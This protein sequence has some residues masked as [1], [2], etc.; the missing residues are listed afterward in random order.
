[1]FARHAVNASRAATVV[2]T[3]V[4]ACALVAPASAA[5]SAL[6]QKKAQRAQA[7]AEL[8]KA[9]SEVA[10]Q[11]AEY[12]ETGRRIEQAQAEIVQVESEITALDAEMASKEQAFQK[13]AVELY[14]S[15]RVGILEVLLGSA[16]FQDF[17]TR[18]HY[19]LMINQRD[20]QL[21]QELRL[22]RSESL[23]LQN[24]L[25]DKV[26]SLTRLQDEADG[27][28]EAI[29]NRIV[30][31]EATAE[32]LGEDIAELMKPPAELGGSTPSGTFDRNTV[33]SDDQ[34]RDY[35]SMTVVEIQAFLNRQ[36]GTLKGYRAVNYAGEMKS[37]A[38][39]IF[40]AANAHRINPK[41]ILV[42]LQK[43][44]SLLAKT[45]PTQEAYD[46]AM[47]CGRADNKTY[48]EYKGFGKQ[49]WWGAQKLDK[50]S[51]PWKPG[52]SKKIDKS[53]IVYPTNASTYSLYM[54]TPHYKG[55][56]SFWMLYWRYFGDPM[57]PVTQ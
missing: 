10:S 25:G 19:L 4:L 12:V 36:P 50:N 52:I 24:S 33:I 22:A 39:M 5:P 7:L 26:A 32:Q 35:D 51:R 18:A 9:R 13:R 14:R 54:Y 34:F 46:W 30:A 20:T 29:E 3:V 44:Q 2:V 15:D 37:A 41:V 48:W 56:F 11:V 28:R 31:L 53:T 1:M 55:T 45:N 27:K 6:E 40:E 23:W 43:E 21:M 57:A 47:G 49:I 17:W 38:E 8:Q 16:S 42:K